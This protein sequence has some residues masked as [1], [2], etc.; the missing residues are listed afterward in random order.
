MNANETL[1]QGLEWMKSPEGKKSMEVYFAKLAQR[2]AIERT[3]AQRIKNHFTD[4][5]SFSTLMEFVLERQKVYDARHYK[6]Y[7]ER[8]LHVTNLLW[9]LASSEGN[10]IDAID[11]LTESFSSMVY[12]YFGWQFAI[13]HG[14]GSV[15]SIYKDKGLIYRIN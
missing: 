11:G 12:D 6:T 4:E 5:T 15:L 1:K 7:S 14:Q 13:T 8:A 10:E 9:E 3:R 2:D